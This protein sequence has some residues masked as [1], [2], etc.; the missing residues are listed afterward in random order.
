LR[1]QVGPRG[2]GRLG[3]LPGLQRACEAGPASQ[4]DPFKLLGEGEPV[5]LPP[6][7]P[8]RWVPGERFIHGQQNCPGQAGA[9]HPPGT[10]PDT[11]AGADGQGPAGTTGGGKA[12]VW[13]ASDGWVSS[14]ACPSATRCRWL[15]CQS[16]RSGLSC[17][18]STKVASSQ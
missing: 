11:T 6:G 17:S 14:A 10:P 13:F 4:L 15:V 7:S 1:Q 2:Q 9:N 8:A 16:G 3:A 12:R 5:P 18:Q